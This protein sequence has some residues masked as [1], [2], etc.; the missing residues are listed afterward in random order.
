MEFEERIERYRERYSI[1]AFEGYVQTLL[2]RTGRRWLLLGASDVNNPSSTIGPS[3]SKPESKKIRLYTNECKMNLNECKTNNNKAPSHNSPFCTS[4][5]AVTKPLAL[6][7]VTGRAPEATTTVDFCF[8]VPMFSFAKGNVLLSV[9]HD[10]QL[11]SDRL[12]LSDPPED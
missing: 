10:E 11:E 12:S 5:P 3:N 4:S 8:I 1:A 2:D 9:L 6:F 7:I